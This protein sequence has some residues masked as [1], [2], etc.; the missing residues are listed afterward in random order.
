VSVL[1][2]L[3]EIAPRHPAAFGHLL[4]VMHWYLSPA[5]PIACAVPT[6]APAS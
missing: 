2:L 4:Q 3:H 1:R 5:R 6:R